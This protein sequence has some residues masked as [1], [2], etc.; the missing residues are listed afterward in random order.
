M[1]EIKRYSAD[2]QQIWDNVVSESRIDTFLFYRHFMDYHSHRFTDCSFVVFRKGKAEAVLPGNI[3]NQV[4]YSHQGL[5]YGGLIT[6]TKVSASNVLEIFELLNAYL[7]NLG[8]NEVVYKPVP[9]I[10]HKIPS[11]EDIYALFRLGAEK[12]ACNISSTIIQDKKL[13]F[14]ES[15][16]S[17]IRKA[18]K[19]LVYLVEDANPID[20]WEIL[21]DNLTANYGTKPVHS[22]DEIIQLKSKFPNNIK[23]YTCKQGD[24]TIGGTVLFVMQHLVH[25]QYISA[26][27][28]GKFSGAL[29]L[30]FDEL[31]NH[32]Y[33]DKPIFD[34]GQSTEQMGHYLNESLIFQKEGFGG[35]GT[36]YEAYKYSL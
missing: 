5:T 8:V 26:S 35:R 30:L 29:D 15:R 16:K 13:A 9:S 25:V 36:V 11:Q 27:E 12:I 7:K 14:I 33:Q 6:T 19:E 1:I 17:G 31:I 4:F 21:E 23:I 24:T 34:F 10:Y 2:M 22:V 18:K 28:A 20:F 32:K 3:V